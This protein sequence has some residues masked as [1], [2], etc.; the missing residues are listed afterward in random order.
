MF[1][2]LPENT[3]EAVFVQE[4]PRTVEPGLNGTI[5]DGV[6][7]ERMDCSAEWPLGFAPPEGSAVG[8]NPANSKRFKIFESE[9]AMQG[10]PYLEPP[11]KTRGPY[12]SWLEYVRERKAA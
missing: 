7:V 11:T 12:R 4:D 6:T 1:L 8:Q 2:V 10:G 9:Q 5:I 3:A